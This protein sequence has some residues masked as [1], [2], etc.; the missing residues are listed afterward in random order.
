MTG[1]WRE[2]Y[3]G[4]NTCN[5]IL[6]EID[7]VPYDSDD[8]KEQRRAETQYLR[9][10]YLFFIA[11]TWG[12][13][14]FSIE[15]AQEAVHTA[16]RTPVETFYNQIVDDL[17]K[18]LPNLPDRAEGVDY[19]RPD[20]AATEALLARV[21]LYRGNYSEASQYARNVINNYDFALID[22]Y[23]SIWDIDNIKN[24]EMVWVVNYSDDPEY[25]RSNLT[26]VDGNEYN[27]SGGLI[28]RDGGNQGH[29]MYEIRY[30]DTGWGMIR[31]VENGRGF[32][33]LDAHQIL[34][35]T[36]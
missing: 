3:K 35:R 19:G 17:T 20:K 1:V 27:N 26:D 28:Q 21:Q 14:H 9:A 4:L 12:G 16:N 10:F 15:P 25:T 34:Y 32:Q 11:E 29:L 31:D 7:N 33:R 8:L 13:V 36:L 2:L 18:A 6:A 24:S 23:A 30:E 5:L 22:N